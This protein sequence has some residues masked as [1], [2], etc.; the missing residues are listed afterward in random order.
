[1]KTV[2]NA[3]FLA[4]LLADATTGRLMP[5]DMNRPYVWEK[6]HV[7]TLFDSILKQIPIG[8]FLLWQPNG[9][10]NLS[11]LSRS[12]LGPVAILKDVQSHTPLSLLL[13]GQNRLATLMWLANMRPDLVT[14]QLSGTEKAT[15]GSGEALVFDGDT[16]SVIF[17]PSALAQ[18]GL[19][20]P[21]WM[22]M[23]SISAEQSVATQ[24]GLR[25]LYL[26]W[27]TFKSEHE[28]DL[29][30][31]QFEAAAEA[32]RDARVTVTTIEDATAEEARA[33][34]LRICRVGVQMSQVDFDRAVG[35]TP[36][37]PADVSPEPECP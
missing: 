25:Q 33:I 3:C 15:W 16:G 36:K 31:T 29:F 19:R 5:A 22:L 30:L 12:R 32:F 18:E 27:E 37:P 9:K 24:K 2:Q 20:V 1:M 28:I 4:S 34:F 13:D 17:V 35:W 8:S 14:A 21:A 23:R 10:A 26:H 7:E 11:Q 6:A